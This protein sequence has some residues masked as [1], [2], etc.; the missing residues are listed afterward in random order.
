[1]EVGT[2]DMGYKP[3]PT[4]PPTHPSYSA[5]HYFIVIKKMYPIAIIEGED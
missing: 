2:K 1:M 3:Q 4:H 5:C